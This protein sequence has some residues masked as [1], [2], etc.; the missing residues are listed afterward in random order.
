MRN[1]VHGV[2]PLGQSRRRA[3]ALAGLTLALGMIAGACGSD[4]SSNADDSD[5]DDTTYSWDYAQYGAPQNAQTLNSVAFADAVRERTDG[6]IDITVRPA[7]ELPYAPAEYLQRVGDGTVEMAEALGGF[8]SGDCPIATLSGLPFLVDNDEAH[9]QI[10]PEFVPFVEECLEGMG[11]HLLWSFGFP[12]VQI[13][14]AGDPP[15]SLDDLKGLSLR[16]LGPESSEWLQAVG[17]EPVTLTTD[18]VASAMQR[19][20]ID[21]FITSADTANTIWAE[22]ADWVYVID[23]GVTPQYAIM[24][25]EEYE[26]LPDGL[27]ST[28]D[29]V[30]EEWQA[31][32][33]D[34]FNARN[35]DAMD[36]LQNEHG[37]TIVTPTDADRE[38]ARQIAAEMWE[39]WA[40][41]LAGEEGTAALKA[42]RD[43]LG[44]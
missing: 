16:Q 36:S 19:G 11:A 6:R 23:F 43:K 14:G 26:K 28:L 12:T 17:V 10:W 40:N 30:A 1:V 2:R 18:E 25:K 29:E 21:G 3:G 7:G 41:G 20:V 32:S 42:I 44:S 4:S 9:K 8:I 35:Q 5:S 15:E 34:F 27:R 33:T 38:R 39:T 37:Y 13:F 22:L 24:S 31:K